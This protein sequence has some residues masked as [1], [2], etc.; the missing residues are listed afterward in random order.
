[1]IKLVISLFYKIVNEKMSPTYK[2]LVTLDRNGYI[3][4]NKQ[5]LYS[6]NLS[7]YLELIHSVT[8]DYI[9]QEIIMCLSS[10]PQAVKELFLEDLSTNNQLHYS[11]LA[12]KIMNERK[13]INKNIN[14]ACAK[15]MA[16]FLK[17]Y[18]PRDYFT[19]YSCL[20]LA[21]SAKSKAENNK[22]SVINE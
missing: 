15:N 20:Y 10:K 4:N 3:F 22:V 2:K 8:N 13:I 14:K 9:V 5:D 19:W 21:L 16:T 18:F 1:M 11:L 12:C 17:G 6:I 7:L